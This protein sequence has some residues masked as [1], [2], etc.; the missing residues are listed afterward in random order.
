MPFK[1]PS[2]NELP[3]TVRN[4]VQALKDYV[5]QQ[6]IRC[7]V[8]TTAERDALGAEAGMIVFNSTV[9]KHQGYDG[10]AW[11]NFY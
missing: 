9:A 6:N 2:P 4:A 11:Q 5:D 3:W 8:V 7:R 1:I 10:T